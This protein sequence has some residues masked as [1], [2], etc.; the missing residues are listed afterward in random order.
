MLSRSRPGLEA[1]DAIVPLLQSGVIKPVVA[2]TFPLSEAA[3]ALRYL[4][5]GHSFGRVVLTIWQA[6]RR[7]ELV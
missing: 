2:K 6:L 3:E 4:V 7:G 1:W 5:E